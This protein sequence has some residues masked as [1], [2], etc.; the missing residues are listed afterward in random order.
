MNTT[1]KIDPILYENR[2]KHPKDSEPIYPEVWEVAVS[3][4]SAVYNSLESKYFFMTAIPN[5]EDNV[6]L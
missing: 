3:M 4:K 6:E 5:V 1:R 2:S